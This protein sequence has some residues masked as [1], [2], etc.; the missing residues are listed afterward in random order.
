MSY[1][2]RDLTVDHIEGTDEPC[3]DCTR[4]LKRRSGRFLSTWF[5]VQCG[6]MSA[7]F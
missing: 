2:S 4:T 1:P 6:D 7:G 5:C 3:P